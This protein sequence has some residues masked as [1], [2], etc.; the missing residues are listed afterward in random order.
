MPE[1]R[2][3]VSFIGS[4]RECT[5]V[6]QFTFTR[7]PGYRFVPGQFMVI[8]LQTREGEQTKHFT[9]SDAPGDE[10]AALTT[11]LTGSAFK[12]ALLGLDPGQTVG[13]AGPSGRLRVPSG[14]RKVAFL[15]GGI[16]VTPASSIVRDAVQTGSGLECLVF[17]GNRD[18]SCI[19][20]KSDFDSYQARDPLLVCVD[21]LAEPTPAWTGERG[22]ITAEI[23]R[24]H[25]DPLDGW[26]WIV[27]GPPP[28]VE[29]MRA[30]LAELRV[31]DSSASFELFA[32]YR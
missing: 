16:G 11:R 9:H 19:P 8:T 30:V 5:D 3:L 24:R 28:M 25:C 27:A 18:E 20:L 15:V 29:P 22:F 10:H 6:A 2:T 1:G 13:F 23:V 12:D 32:G 7:P 17:R 21:V 31:P 4:R 26:H 14:A